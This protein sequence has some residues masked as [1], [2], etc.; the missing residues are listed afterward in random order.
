[1]SEDGP[2]YRKFNVTRTDGEHEQGK[3]HDGCAYW[4]LDVTHDPYA[5]A[6]L[7]AYAD[8]CCVTHPT[9]GDDIARLLSSADAYDHDW[10]KCGCRE[11]MC[12]HEPFRIPFRFSDHPE[13]T[14]PLP[15]PDSESGL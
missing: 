6:A 14:N 3:K 1:M 5:A 7:Q 13:P 8:A 2:I 9:L 12:P 4:V 10:G 15:E 11:A